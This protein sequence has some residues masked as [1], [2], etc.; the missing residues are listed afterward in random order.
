[1][2]FPVP[3][4]EIRTVENSFREECPTWATGTV[5]LRDERGAVV[6]CATLKRTGEASAAVTAYAASAV[7]FPSASLPAEG[8]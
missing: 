3:A 2:S 1:M 5:V 7:R 4:E 6:G 8:E